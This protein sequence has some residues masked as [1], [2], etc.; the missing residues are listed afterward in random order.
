ML[1]KD[2]TMGPF[3]P[4]YIGDYRIVFTKGN[5]VKIMP[6]PGEITKVIYITDARY[7][8]ST[9]NIILKL[10]DFPVW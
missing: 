7:V 9:D 10:L 1:I 6:S 3:D 5:Q 4:T 8:L 2:C